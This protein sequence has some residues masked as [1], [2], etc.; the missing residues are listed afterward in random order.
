MWKNAGFVLC[1]LLASACY[2]VNE[3]NQHITDIENGCTNPCIEKH[4][5]ALAYDT[6]KAPQFREQVEE[7]QSM[8]FPTT[9]LYFPE[10]PEELIAISTD[11]YFIRYLYNPALSR[12]VPP[13]LR[14]QVMDGYSGEL[15][16]RQ[17]ARL[18]RRVEALFEACGCGTSAPRK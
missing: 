5:Q 3:R 16:A 2:G 1:S 17:R 4:L 12:N 11:W 10:G 13:M 14:Y 18:K 9:I 7:I 8:V 15:D 6:T